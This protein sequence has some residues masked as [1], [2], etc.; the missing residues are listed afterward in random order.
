MA[1]KIESTATKLKGWN[2]WKSDFE[3]VPQQ[4]LASS[5]WDK[6]IEPWTWTGT[7]P[8]TLGLGPRNIPQPLLPPA[9]THFGRGSRFSSFPVDSTHSASVRSV[10][11]YWFLHRTRTQYSLPTVLVSLAELLTSLIYE[12]YG[13]MQKIAQT[14]QCTHIVQFDINVDGTCLASAEFLQIAC[15]VTNV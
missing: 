14:K 3:F 13:V 9:S 4:K 2:G 5:F 6:I 10:G 7:G 8:R 1:L 15:E 12:W 11:C